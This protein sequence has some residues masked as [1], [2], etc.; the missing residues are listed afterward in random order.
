MRSYRL[1]SKVVSRLKKNPE[2]RGCG[3]ILKLGE[4]VYVTGLAGRYG[5]RPFRNYFCQDC[6]NKPILVYPLALT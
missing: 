5:R 4:R 1:T 3:R 6:W 2:C